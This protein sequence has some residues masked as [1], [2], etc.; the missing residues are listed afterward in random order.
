MFFVIEELNE[1]HIG[2]SQRTVEVLHC[3]DLFCFNIL[4][5]QNDS[6]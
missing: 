4:S 1:T 5:K 6:K 2:F 3:R